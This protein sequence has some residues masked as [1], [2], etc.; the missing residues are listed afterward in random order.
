[1]VTLYGR[2]HTPDQ[3]RRRVGHMDQLA[4]IKPVEGADGLERGN[5]IFE[6]WT[7]SGLTFQVQ[8]DRALDICACRHKGVALGWLS[9][10]REVHPAHYEPSGLGWLR[11]FAGG[12]L[13]TCG[14]DQFGA[15]S[16]DGDD[17]LGL[18]GRISSLP[19]RALAHRAQWDD[20]AYR[21]D[22]EGEVRQARL[23]GENLVLRRRIST[24]L[25][26]SSIRIRDEVS[27]E[28]FSQHPHMMLYH[29]NVGF[30]MLS[31]EARLRID[32]DLTEPR[33]ETAA[34]G[35]ALWDRFQLP[36][37]GYA[38]QVFHHMPS[39]G[40]DGLASVVLENRAIGLSLRWTYEQASL[41]HLFQW[42]MM[43]EGAY[44]LGIEPA[45][46]SGIHGRAIARESGV[47]P[48]LAPGQSVTYDIVLEVIEHSGR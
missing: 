45:N 43:G 24:Q 30:P 14:L 37:A 25:G 46:C 15:P 42:K 35:L 29:F 6:V 19:A 1:M 36:T 12:L 41:P 33:D 39:A 40:D 20:G 18:H 48:L 44:V 26:S 5:R 7:G 3:L 13:A 10:V 47:L 17:E 9:P 32:S 23:F 27:N 38:E 31:E 11:T 8:A 21:L 16:V 28:G 22:I 2:E 34:E 4:G